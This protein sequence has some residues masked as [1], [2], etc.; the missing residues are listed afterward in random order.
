MFL[1]YY[2]LDLKVR[3]LLYDRSA[4]VLGYIARSYGVL[5]SAYLG[6]DNN[7]DRLDVNSYN[8]QNIRS[9]IQVWAGS[10]T[11]DIPISTHGINNPMGL[12]KLIL[13]PSTNPRTPDSGNLS[14]TSRWQD[15][16]FN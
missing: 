2:R 3:N 8:P 10:Q 13:S 14:Y 12:L 15:Y 7:T 11:V 16:Q 4:T 1:L 9:R 6:F 5:N